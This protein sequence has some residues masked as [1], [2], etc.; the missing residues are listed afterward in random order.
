V[1]VILGTAYLYLKKI[2]TLSF[3]SNIRPN[4]VRLNPLVTRVASEAYIFSAS[5]KS[6]HL[7]M[8]VKPDMQRDLFELMLKVLNSVRLIS[9]GFLQQQCAEMCNL[10]CRN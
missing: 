9:V 8:P 6:H 10:C 2:F 7:E 3:S 4:F 5:L 1:T